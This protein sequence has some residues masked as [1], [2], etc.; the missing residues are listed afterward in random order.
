MHYE[1]SI[2]IDAPADVVWRVLTDVERWP[3]WTRSE[4]SAKL[5]ADGPFRVG[6][7]AKLGVAGSPLPSLWEVTAL[8]EGRAFVWENKQ[9]G[10][11]NIAGHYVEAQ[12]AGSRVRLTIDMSGPLAM[13]MRPYLAHVTRRNVAWEAEGLKQRAEES[14]P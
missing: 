10:L 14:S 9:A 6:S 11:R 2:D 1:Q 7:R 3:E 4:R 8:Y 13:L 12:G 5:E